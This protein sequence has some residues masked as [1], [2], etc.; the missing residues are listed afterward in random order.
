MTGADVASCC[1]LQNLCLAAHLVMQHVQEVIVAS[2]GHDLASCFCIPSVIAS[3]PVLR[4]TVIA[5]EPVLRN[6]VIASEPVLRERRLLLTGVINLLVV[7]SFPNL[8]M[9]C[10]L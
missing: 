1:M 9:H 8:V 3:E 7:A 4:D 5:S 2:H 6:T 10:K